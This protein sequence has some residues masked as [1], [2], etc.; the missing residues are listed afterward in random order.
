MSAPSPAASTEPAN[1]SAASDAKKKLKRSSVSFSNPELHVDL[2][3]ETTLIKLGKMRSGECNLCGT[4][5][6]YKPWCADYMWF[7]DDEG[8]AHTDE[9]PDAVSCAI[10]G[11]K[12]WHVLDK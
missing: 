10:I 6:E 3:P 4:L 2:H 1:D 11:C 5:F 8:N 12:G 7:K 9:L